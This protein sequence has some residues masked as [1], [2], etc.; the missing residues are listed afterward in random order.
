MPKARPGTGVVIPALPG[1]RIVRP[2]GF[3]VRPYRVRTLRCGLHAITEVSPIAQVAGIGEIAAVAA[4]PADPSGVSLTTL[5]VELEEHAA[6][7]TAPRTIQTERISAHLVS[8]LRA[9]LGNS[10]FTHLT[11]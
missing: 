11:L 2:R 10:D 3:R 7:Q 8:A 6:T 5:L 4:P 1:R 9:I